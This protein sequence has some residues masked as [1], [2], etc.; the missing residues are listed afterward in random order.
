[1]HLISVDLPAPFGPEQAVHLALED[2]EVD[3]LER[4]DAGELLH[5]VAHLE[6]LGHATTS[7]RRLPVRD[8]QAGLDPLRAAAPHR[9]LVLDRQDAVEAALVERIHVAGE[10]D[11]AETRDPVA[12]PAH[13][14]RVLFAGGDPPEEPVAVAVRRE[15]LGVLGVRVRDPVDVGPQRGDGIDAR[16]RGGARGR[17]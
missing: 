6:D 8:P 1:M 3:P 2:V 14:P 10:V 13:A 12:P 7:P 4:L 17:S 15:G 16:A 5:E 9:I 11:L